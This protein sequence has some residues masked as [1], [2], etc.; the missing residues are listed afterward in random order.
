MPSLITFGSM[1]DRAFGYGANSVP[2]TITASYLIVA[3]GGAGGYFTGGGGGAGGL[4]TGTSTLT[5][6][7]T[8]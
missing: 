8:Y 5:T 7:T 2:T 3:G 1:S 6:G 4:L